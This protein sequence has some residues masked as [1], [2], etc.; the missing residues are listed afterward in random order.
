[1]SP[2]FY[3]CFPARVLAGAIIH[4]SPVDFFDFGPVLALQVPGYAGF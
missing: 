4:A 2:L 1:M 3:G